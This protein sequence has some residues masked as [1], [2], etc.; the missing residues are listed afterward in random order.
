MRPYQGDLPF[1]CVAD[2]DRRYYQDFGVERALRSVLH[3]RAM[4][5]AIRGLATVPSSPFAGGSQPSGLPADF[6]LDER[7]VILAAH[8]GR[9]ADD[10]WS[11]D[12]VL[13]LA[14]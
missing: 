10:Q 1:P 7:G 13:A 4:A 12:E 6:M 5:A 14:A 3:P 8:Y 9:H 2:P 11:L